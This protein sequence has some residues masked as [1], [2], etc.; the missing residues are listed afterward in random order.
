MSKVTHLARREASIPT[1]TAWL[2][3][4]NHHVSRAVVR[5]LIYYKMCRVCAKLQRCEAG[6]VR[7]KMVLRKIKPQ[8]KTPVVCILCFPRKKVPAWIYTFLPFPFGQPY[9]MFFLVTLLS[10]GAKEEERLPFS[11]CPSIQKWS[12]GGYLGMNRP[13]L[14]KD[15]LSI[16]P[17]P[18]L[19][20]NFTRPQPL[21]TPQ[22][23]GK[24]G[25]LQ[26]FL[27]HP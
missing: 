25:Q 5:C 1:Q 10:A 20:E 23:R 27:R 24:K 15:G 18:A 3:V 7:K 17:P 2:Q 12:N 16:S 4:H 6:K 21:G 8:G 26:G 11:P 14:G 22:G 19:K 9:W 13:C